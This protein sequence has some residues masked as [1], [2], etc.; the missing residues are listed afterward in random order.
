VC[1]NSLFGGVGTSRHRTN[2]KERQRNENEQRQQ[3]LEKSGYKKF[4]HGLVNL[5]FSERG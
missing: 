4:E 2:E 5:S 1:G 3:T